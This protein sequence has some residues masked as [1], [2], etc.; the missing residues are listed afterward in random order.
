MPIRCDKNFTEC[1]TWKVQHPE[2]RVNQ[3]TKGVAR[4][5]GGEESGSEDNEVAGDEEGES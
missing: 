5:F 4:M 3:S 2:D 1:E